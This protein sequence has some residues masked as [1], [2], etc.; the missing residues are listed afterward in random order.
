MIA[1]QFVLTV[2]GYINL[3][4]SLKEKQQ[5]DGMDFDYPPVQFLFPHIMKRWL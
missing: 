1:Y 3:V 5:V 2:Y 4:K